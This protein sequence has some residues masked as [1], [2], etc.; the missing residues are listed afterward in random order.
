MEDGQFEECDLTLRDVGAEWIAER[1]RPS[2]DWEA[3]GLL[4]T[5]VRIV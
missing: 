1:H 5:S 3:V 4:L 2:F